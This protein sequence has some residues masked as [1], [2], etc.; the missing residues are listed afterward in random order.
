MVGIIYSLGSLFVFI[1]L[2]CVPFIFKKVGGYK[3]ALGVTLLFA[4]S[5]LG[6]AFAKNGVTASI[7][8]ILSFM[9][10]DIFLS[11][12]DEFLK[13]STNDSHLGRARGVYLIVA[14]IAVIG[15]QFT[16]WLGLGLLPFREIYLLAFVTVLL[17]FLLQSMVKVGQRPL[18]G[19]IRLGRSRRIKRNEY[20]TKT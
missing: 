7:F 13:I 20:Y 19:Q 5:L 3:F 11:T 16:F 17:L 2:L 1:S 6:L 15:V 12:L 9:F 10:T 8:M 14:H 4:L 18:R